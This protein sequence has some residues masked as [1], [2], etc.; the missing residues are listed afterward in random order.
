MIPD[1]TYLTSLWIQRIGW[2]SIQL[3]LNKKKLVIV[4]TRLGWNFARSY[5]ASLEFKV[6]LVVRCEDAFNINHS[7]FFVT[8]LDDWSE[9]PFSDCIWGI[10]IVV[11]AN[12]TALSFGTTNV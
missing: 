8:L 10:I 1:L 5:G 11:I 7:P 4:E 6:S 3:I 9:Y 2:C 12:F